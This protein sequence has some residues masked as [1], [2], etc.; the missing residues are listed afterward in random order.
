LDIL[1]MDSR[2]LLLWSA[3]LSLWTAGSA[4][5][6]T[7]TSAEDSRSVVFLAAG[8]Q[9]EKPAAASAGRAEGQAS[10]AI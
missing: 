10:D 4:M 5:L 6:H 2:W 8:S 9:E 3:V 1:G 7:S